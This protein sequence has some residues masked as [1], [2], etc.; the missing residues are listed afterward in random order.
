MSE[1]PV[2]GQ[3]VTLSAT[4]LLPVALVPGTWFYTEP[5]SVPGSSAEP[6]G[7]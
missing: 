2:S 1:T 4:W 5:S 6:S 3:G 7:I